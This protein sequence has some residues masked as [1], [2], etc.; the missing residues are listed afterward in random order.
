MT[1]IIIQNILPC[2][3]EL[4]YIEK[5]WKN[6]KNDTDAN[7]PKGDGKYARKSLF[8]EVIL[9][10]TEITIS[11]NWKLSTWSLYEMRPKVYKLWNFGKTETPWGVSNGPK[12]LSEQHLL[13]FSVIPAKN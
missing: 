13:L 4:H 2:R 5:R 1:I 12:M 9:L 6:V 3:L 8:E 11:E 7:P 10:L